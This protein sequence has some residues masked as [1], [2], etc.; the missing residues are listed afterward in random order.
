MQKAKFGHGGKHFS[1]T[2]LFYML[3]SKTVFSTHICFNWYLSNE[4]NTFA[5]NS[6]VEPTICFIEKISLSLKLFSGR[7]CGQSFIT[8][9]LH[10]KG[11]TVFRF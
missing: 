8:G 10:P 11:N 1:K 5:N 4:K 6:R 3:N 9:I 2:F 7:F